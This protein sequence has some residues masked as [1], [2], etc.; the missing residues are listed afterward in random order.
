MSETS[1]FLLFSDSAPTILTRDSKAVFGS[2]LGLGFEFE[3]LSNAI[4]VLAGFSIRMPRS[5]TTPRSSAYLSALSQ[6]IEK[7]LQR[8]RFS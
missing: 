4:I 5:P 3:F 7:K 2:Q 6:E 1:S 8:V